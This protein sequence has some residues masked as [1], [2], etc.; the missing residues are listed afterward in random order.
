MIKKKEMIF[1]SHRTYEDM[2]HQVSSGRFD[3]RD[4]DFAGYTWLIDAAIDNDLN[5][6]KKLLDLGASP[7]EKANGGQN[8]LMW[9]FHWR[10]EEMVRLLIEYG[11][12][13]NEIDEENDFVL[14]TIFKFWVSKEYMDDMFNV[15]WEFHHRIDSGCKVLLKGIRLKSLFQT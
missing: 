4:K 2:K 8:S 14:E 9:A 13:L 1:L 10:N 15:I 11:A 12:D 3:L 7:N 6:M 5:M